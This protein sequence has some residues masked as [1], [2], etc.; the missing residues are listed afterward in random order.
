MM[1]GVAIGF[2]I[3][4]GWGVLV[5]VSNDGVLEIVDRRHIAIAEAAISGSKQPYH[6]AENLELKQ[7]EEHISRCF[8]AS[9]Q[10][11][12]S[13]IREVL[14]K[15]Q[16]NACTI[17]GCAILMGSGRP[18]PSLEKIL[19]SHALIH[20]AEG[21][22][23]RTVVRKGCED[24]GISVTPLRERDL[25]ERVNKTFRSKANQVKQHILTLGKQVGPPWTQDEKLAALAAALILTV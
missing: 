20:A 16:K 22:F 18:L 1:K 24:T 23:F 13:A 9:Q 11:A 6:Y 15:M 25:D 12:L 14:S 21:E 2:R 8:A 10:L 7:A 17:K 4:S 19:S 5:A 3:H